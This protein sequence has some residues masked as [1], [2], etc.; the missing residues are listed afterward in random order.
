VS[1]APAT[2]AS[3]SPSRAS[4]R[5]AGSWATPP[6]LHDGSAPTL[7]AVLD[8]ADGQHGDASALTDLERDALA[9]W[10]AGR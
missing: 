10:L 7:R 8:A 9:R 1:T 5:L 4:T 2:A 6:Y 3:A